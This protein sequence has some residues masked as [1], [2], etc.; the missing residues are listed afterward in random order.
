MAFTIIILMSFTFC[1]VISHGGSE[2]DAT[3]QKEPERHLTVR[4]SI[5]RS[6]SFGKK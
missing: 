5:L 1:L 2:K 6:N 3:E 4:D